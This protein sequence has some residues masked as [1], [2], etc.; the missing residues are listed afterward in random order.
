MT[1]T[2][3]ILTKARKEGHLSKL[4]PVLDDLRNTT[5]RIHDDLYRTALAEADELDHD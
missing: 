1:G 3:G 4:A 2:L 5:I